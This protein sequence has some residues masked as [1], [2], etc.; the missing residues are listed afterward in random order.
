[1]GF[2]WRFKNSDDIPMHIDVSPEIRLKI[3]LHRIRTR[4]VLKYDLD[5]NFIERFDSIQHAAKSVGTCHSCIARCCLGQRKQSSGFKWK[6]E[7]E[8][9]DV[10]DV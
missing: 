4:P 5:G 1:M 8:P 6:Y 10:Q 2:I 3:K 7:T 9:E